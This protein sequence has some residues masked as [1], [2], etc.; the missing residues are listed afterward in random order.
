MPHSQYKKGHPLMSRYTS[1]PLDISPAKAKSI[2]HLP[3]EQEIFVPSTTN[4]SKLIKQKAYDKR[5]NTVRGFLS[6]EFGGFTSVSGTGGYYSSDKNSVIK[7][8]VTVVTSFAQIEGFPQKQKHLLSQ[9][10]KWRKQWGQ[11]SMGYEFEGD[12]YYM[13]KQ[14][15]KR[16]LMKRMREKR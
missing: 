4:A 16:K 5:I 15:R 7:E 3:I 11:E 14:E 1:F 2:F 12:L 13:G 8:P 6:K 10:S 9:L